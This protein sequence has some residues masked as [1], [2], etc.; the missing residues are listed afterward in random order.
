M[1][2]RWFLQP[3][4]AALGFICNA[5]LAIFNVDRNPVL[6]RLL[7][8]FLYDQYAAGATAGEVAKTTREIKGMG[9]NGVILGYAKEVVLQDPAGRRG[10]SEHEHTAAQERVIEQW[11]D[12]QIQTLRMIDRGDFL[13]VK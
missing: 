1:G 9:Y 7:R 13:A 4:L 5:K 10:V 3:A 12:E 8:L 6:N 2:K 11:K